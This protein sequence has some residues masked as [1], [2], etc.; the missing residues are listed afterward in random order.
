MNFLPTLDFRRTPV[1]LLITAVAAALEIAS[2]LDPGLR[3]VLYI[4]YRL[5]ILSPMW[6]GEVWR[7]LTSCLL[8]GDFL[9]AAFNI[10]WMFLFGTALEERFGPWRMAAL[11]VLLGYASMLP[12][13]V[14]SNYDVERVSAQRGAVGLSGVVYGLFGILLVGR[15]YQADLQAVCSDQ[16]AM[17]MAGWF[18]FC[19]LT[20]QLEVMNVANIAHGAG[21]LFGALYGAAIFVP[22]RRWMWIAASVI[23]TLLVLSLLLYV[24]GHT[25]YEQHQFNQMLRRAGR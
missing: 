15:K 1:T 7:P 20:T 21:M 6:S 14:I 19:I 11:V 8:H 22:R 24:P 12:Q 4:D 17:L 25:L 2:T 3:E 18:V 16:T 9:H 10:Y 13:F 23:L 5:G